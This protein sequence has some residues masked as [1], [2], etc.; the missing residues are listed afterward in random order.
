[1][2]FQHNKSLSCEMLE[3]KKDKNALF[4]I[5][6]ILGEDIFKRILGV[7]TANVAWDAL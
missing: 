3:K 7:T 1:M 6:Q 2:I 5:Y 4:F